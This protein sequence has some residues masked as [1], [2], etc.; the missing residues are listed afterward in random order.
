MTTLAERALRYDR[1]HARGL[2]ALAYRMLGS[3]A[4]ADDAVQET[5]IRLSRTDTTDVD[6]LRAWLTT[7]VARVALNLLRSR[8][9][10]RET[11]LE[12]HLPDPIEIERRGTS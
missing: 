1:D 10:R 12:P 2:R 3:L 5:W 6:D 7:V 8:K 9:T 4:E 11:S